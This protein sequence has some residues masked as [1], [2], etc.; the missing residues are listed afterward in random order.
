MS[1]I[2]VNNITNRDGSTG[3][4]VAGIPV[5]D[6]TS[7]FV[8]PSGNTAERGSRG[9]GLFGGGYVSGRQNTID[10]ITIATA[11]N[12]HDFGDL[13]VARLGAGSCAS[14]VEGFWG[15]GSPSGGGGVNTVDYVTISSTG[16]AFSFGELTVARSYTNSLSNNIRGIWIGGG[17]TNV[18]DYINLSSKSNASDFGDMFVIADSV[19]SFA[20]AT[21]GIFAGGRNAPAF[22]TNSISYV[23]ISTTGSVFDFGDLSASKG[24]F[25]GCSNSIRGLF[26]GGVSGNAPTTP[27]NVIEYVTISSLGDAIDFGDLTTTNTRD[28]A[29]CASSTRGV[30]A[31]G[32][33]NVS[34][35]P[36]SDVIDYVTIMSTGNAADFGDLTQTRNHLKGCSDSHGGLG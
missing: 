17:A 16:N 29:S 27:L 12:A 31:G 22:P 5:V 11:G 23:T 14:L 2:R 26:G 4:T 3:T 10:Y 20:S 28:S 32:D 35:Y 33:N 34:P 18:I 9:R 36:K 6:S 21:R 25:G 7:H 1:E 8:V 19:A 30:F 15:G 13:N 24:E